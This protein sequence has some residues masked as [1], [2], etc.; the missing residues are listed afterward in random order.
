MFFFFLFFYKRA[1][2]NALGYIYI[3]YV[4]IYSRTKPVKHIDDYN[5]SDDALLL[6]TIKRFFFFFSPVFVLLYSVTL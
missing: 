5:I 1:T 6:I 3:Y 4:F 2:R